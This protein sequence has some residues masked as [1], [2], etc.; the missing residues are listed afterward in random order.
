MTRSTPGRADQGS[1]TVFVVFFSMVALALASLLVDAGN[2]VNAQ[3][4]AADLAEQAARAAADAVSVADLRT[5]TVVIDQATAC[6][7]ALNLIQ[8][9]DRASQVDAAMTAP[10]TYPSPRQV[11]VYVSVTTTPLISAFFGSFTMRAHETAC[12]E[13]GITGGVGC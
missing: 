6:T 10:C 5:G 11:T 7:D 3:E 8:A 12:A 13:F 4:R 1:V 9:Y 2:A